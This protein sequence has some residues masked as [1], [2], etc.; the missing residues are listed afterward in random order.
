VLDEAGKEVTDYNPIIVEHNGG[1][2]DTVVL[3]LTLVNSSTMHY[4]RNVVIQVNSIP[5]VNASLFFK[6]DAVPQMLSTKSV[7]RVY[8]AE[9]V[10][11]D[12]MLTVK[13][14]T[15]EQVVTGVDLKV[16]G[17]KYPVPL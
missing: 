14:G 1:I 17:M 13:P 2:G 3:P 7:F 8:P 6:D 4:Y 12:L 10:G 5:P 9:R 16:F 15:P 11:F